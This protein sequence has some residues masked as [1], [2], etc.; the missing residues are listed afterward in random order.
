KLKYS[1]VDYVKLIGKDNIRSILYY[2][3]LGNNEYIL[4]NTNLESLDIATLLLKEQIL[5]IVLLFSSIGIVFS[6]ILSKMI[7]KPILTLTKSAKELKEG[8]YDVKFDGGNVAELCE[9]A[10]LLT[11]AA[12]E[13]KNTDELRRDLMA[14]VSHDLK[15]P[16]TMIKAYAEKLRDFK[17]KDESK[18]IKDLNVIIQESERLN[19]LVNDLLDLSKLESNNTILDI[20]EY[21][22][23]DQLSDVLKRYDLLQEE[24]KVH[25]ELSLPK[26]SVIVKADK[27]RMDQV[28][29]NLINNAIEHT[30]DDR[31]VIISVKTRPH[32]YTI[33]IKNTG[34]SLTKEEI[35]L[36][37]NRYYTK[38]KNHKRNVVGTGLG[39]S[40][41]K[42]ILEKHNFEFGI[43]SKVEFTTF[44]FRMK[45]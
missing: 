19:G 9:L 26:E 37:W 17:Y 20:K 41:V 42:N 22:L 45:K 34:K 23:L 39:L 33:S 32:H 14:N 11:V 21:N 27:K 2:V 38:N 43:D 8:N 35:A 31:K 3:D 15:T 7:T 4:L 6:V 36:V 40:I 44:Y 12:A 29:Y 30:G 13:M 5:Y 25:F 28:F 24:G 1:D 10:D 16:L 18:R